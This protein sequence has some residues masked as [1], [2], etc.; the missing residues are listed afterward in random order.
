MEKLTVA[1][2][3]GDV[4]RYIVDALKV[5]YNWGT[6]FPDCGIGPVVVVTITG[7]P[8][9]LGQSI[10]ICCHALEHPIFETL[11]SGGT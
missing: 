3:K 2:E 9:V 4:R 10:Y 6:K 11:H 8:L 5:K 7:V 1:L